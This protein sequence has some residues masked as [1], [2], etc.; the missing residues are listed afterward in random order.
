M[1]KI[2]LLFFILFFAGA[3]FPQQEVAEKKHIL[4]TSSSIF[5]LSTLNLTDNYISPLP[6]S[7]IGLKITSENNRLYSPYFN[8]LSVTNKAK[9]NFGAVTNPTQTASMLFLGLNFAWGMHYHFHPIANMQIL[10]GG[11]WDIDFGFKYNTRNVNNPFNMDLSTNLNLSAV[12]IY[13]IPANKRTFRLQAA[14]ASPWIGCMFAPAQGSSY[15][16]IFSLQAGGKFV[17]FSS[18]HNKQAFYQ[19]YFVEIPFKNSFWRFGFSG[20]SLKYMANDMIFKKND[21]TLFLGYTCLFSRFTRKNP[22][23]EYFIGF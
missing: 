18:F 6:Y 10:T 8:N 23:P 20:D 13:D 17:H 2:F 7:G 19:C 4:R 12:V 1:K 16:E 21:F 15:Y 22:A 9:L 11:L 5:G 3:M 14:F